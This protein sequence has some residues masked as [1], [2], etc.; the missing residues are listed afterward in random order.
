[1]SKH[2][3][4]QYLTTIFSFLVIVAFFHNWVLTY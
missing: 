3:L 4:L 1:M 2:N